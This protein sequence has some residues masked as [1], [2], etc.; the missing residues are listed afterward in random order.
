MS[1]P[2]GRWR[3]DWQGP[4]G[5]PGGLG[6]ASRQYVRALRRAG[7]PVRAS[8]R[9]GLPPSG[10]SGGGAG[11]S[12][13]R[14]LVYHH[15]PH[16]LDA[17]EARRRGYDRVVLNTVWETTRV[18]ARWRGAI[19]RYDAV[20]VPSRHNV[21]ALRDSGVTVPVH[22]APHGV[23]SRRFR[24]GRRPA[25]VP[26]ASGRFVFL[27]VFSFQHRKN[28][29]ALL[30]AYAEE[31]SD[32]DRVLLVVKTSGWKDEGGAVG[33]ER[34]IRRYLDTLRLPHRPAPVRVIS[35]Q[36]GE[37]RLQGLY[38]AANAFVLPTRGEGVG[39]PFMEALA[40]GVPVIAPRWGGQ[41][42]FLTDANSFSVPY[43]L[44][45]PA[46]SM[47]GRGAISRS[48]RGLFA[49]KG[50]LWAEADLAGLK[51][52]MRAASRDRALC[53][54]KGR[55]GRRDMQAFSWE[56]AGRKLRQALERIGSEPGAAGGPRRGAREPGTAIVS[57]KGARKP[58]ETA[59]V[60][61]EGARK[62]GTAIVSREGVR[63]RGTARRGGA[64]E[65]ETEIVS[66]KGGRRP[67]ASSRKRGKR[68][69]RLAGLGPNTRRRASTRLLRSAL[70]RRS[71]RS[72][73][74][75]PTGPRAGKGGRS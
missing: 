73:G 8:A 70:P 65:P 49:Q 43:R 55:Q 41:A 22:L 47:Q 72:T 38:A 3:V 74:S 15:P 71:R 46:E 5:R 7:L 11:S 20:I 29:E 1:R 2:G 75:R 48:F 6:G 26:E 60:S 16:T 57:R 45:P 12:G 37:G 66:R 59:N 10:S 32:K 50:Q 14:M 23:D 40:S 27:S 18:P 52:Q 9:I 44:R 63:K 62:P 28:P 30:R 36:I 24:P 56:A 69:R 34:R 61:R 54:R 64:L 33:A 17:D 51:R 13:R 35:G 67:G 58:R 19:D 39:M 68:G 42:D 25:G 21:K 53:A 31:F 4:I